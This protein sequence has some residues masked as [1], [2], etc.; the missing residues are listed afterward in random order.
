MHVLDEVTKVT[1]RPT[2]KDLARQTGIAYE[3]VQRIL[4]GERQPRPGEV[5][6]LRHAAGLR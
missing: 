1:R 2:I 6:R 3:R 4:R 5:E